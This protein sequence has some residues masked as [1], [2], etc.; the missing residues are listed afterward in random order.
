MNQQT[1][2]LLYTHQYVIRKK[3]HVSFKKLYYIFC[4]GL[5]INLTKLHC[6]YR[7]DTLNVRFTSVS[8]LFTSISVESREKK[9]FLRKYCPQKKFTQK[10]IFAGELT[11]RSK[12]I[13]K[14]LPISI[15]K[16][17]LFTAICVESHQGCCFFL[18][19]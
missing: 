19:P 5:T 1:C 13:F 16:L 18:C 7:K 17:P 14:R 15:Y 6:R 8:F 4:L 11:G 10:K 3:I 2:S 9:S 12:K